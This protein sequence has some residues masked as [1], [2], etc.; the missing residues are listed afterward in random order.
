MH[1]RPVLHLFL[2]AGLLTLGAAAPPKFAT[3]F[4]LDYNISNLQFG[5]CVYGKWWMDHQ[6][7]SG[8]LNLRERQD[9]YNITLHPQSTIKDY[10]QHI[11]VN[12]DPSLPGDDHACVSPIPANV[13]QQAWGLPDDA[14]Q[15]KNVD[16]DEDK[17]E[18]EER[19]RVFH[20][21]QSICVDF[22]ITKGVRLPR[23]I[24]YFG[25]CTSCIHVSPNEVLAE[26]HLYRNFSFED[27]PKKEMSIPADAAPCNHGVAENSAARRGF[28]ALGGRLA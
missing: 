2:S 20:K 28:L 7:A 11:L 23:R 4:S 27:I 3:E 14:C 16:E 21:E 15:I 18:E 19:W 13:T 5:F 25:L 17:E 6:N 8:F 24:A 1:H 26:N 9:S 12:L 22:W 10:R